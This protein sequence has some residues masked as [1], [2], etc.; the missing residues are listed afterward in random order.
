MSPRSNVPCVR[1]CHISDGPLLWEYSCLRKSVCSSTLL[2]PGR[3]EI[4][5]GVLEYSC[6]RIDLYQVVPCIR[7]LSLYNPLGHCMEYIPVSDCP[8][9]SEHPC[10]R[11]SPVSDCT[12]TLLYP[13]RGEISRV[14]TP[15]GLAL[16]IHSYQLQLLLYQ[17]MWVPPLFATIYT[18]TVT[19]LHCWAVYLKGTVSREFFALVF[20][21]NLFILVLLE[22][23]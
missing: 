4:S 16:H 18:F 1:S 13:G 9:V 21:L 7:F 19:L 20:F 6:F 17:G 15:Q 22:K 14:H 12:S 3:A 23:P 10:I 11:L 8:P 5:R 2:F